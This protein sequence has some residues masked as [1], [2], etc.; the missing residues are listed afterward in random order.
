MDSVGQGG[1][2]GSEGDLPATPSRSEI[3]RELDL[4]CERFHSLLRDATASDLRRRSDGTRSNNRQLL[5]HRLFGYVIV[6]ASCRWSVSLCRQPGHVSG[7]FATVLNSATGPFHVVNYLG[8]VGGATV[9]TRRR[10]HD[11]RNIGHVN[12]PA[13][14]QHIS[15]SLSRS[16]S[17]PVAVY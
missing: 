1:G 3:H 4:A 5:F 9:L 10:M 11:G 6:P 7:T 14:D 2:V 12:S 8:Y 16:A 15:H 13:H 17:G